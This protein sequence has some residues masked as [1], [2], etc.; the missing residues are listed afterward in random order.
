MLGATARNELAQQLMPCG[1]VR[2]RFHS[3]HAAASMVDDDPLALGQL[4]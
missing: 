1:A 3:D 4:T 2:E